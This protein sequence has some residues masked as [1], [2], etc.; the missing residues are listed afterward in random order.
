MRQ[1]EQQP[2]VDRAAL[3][4]GGVS[5]IVGSLAFFGFRRA[6]GDLP[7][8]DAHA[9][10]RFITEHPLYAGVHLG[11]ILGVLAWVGG[12]IALA[13]T[14]RHGFA[15]VLGRL[16][17][18][19]VLVGAAVFIVEHSVDGVA[20]Q[21]LAEAWGAA[22]SADQ[23]DLELAAQ[24]VFTMLRG[25]S[26]TATA[27]IWGVALVLFGRAVTLEGYPAWLGKTGSAIGATTILGATALIFQPNLFPGVLLYGL[28]VS[29]VAQLWSLVLGLLMWRRAG[30]SSA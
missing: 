27:I 2:A 19:S 9:A 28:L 7:A 4:H 24:T 14:L 25:I 8:A 12:L 20:G 17:A 18:V 3:K 13:G 23:A 15:R 16:G 21:D 1:E 5:A 11:A 22:P 10:L 29:V 26:L 6:H 30:G